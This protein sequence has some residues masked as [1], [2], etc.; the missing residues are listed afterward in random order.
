MMFRAF[1][2]HVRGPM[3]ACLPSTGEARVFY[4]VESADK[5]KMGE[6]GHL[7]P[8]WGDYF[9]ACGDWTVEPDTRPDPNAAQ[10]STQ[11]D[12]GA[13]PPAGQE[14][15]ARAPNAP[16]G[17]DEGGAAPTGGEG[18]APPDSQP[19]TVDPVVEAAADAA[20]SEKGRA[21]ARRGR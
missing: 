12:G 15:A 16:G 20:A 4:V 5:P 11:T 2:A 10:A 13:T 19:A 7:P 21:G 8:A 14:S 17:V 9:K 18:A 3:H 6:I 1:H